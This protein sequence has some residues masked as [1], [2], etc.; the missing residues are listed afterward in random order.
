MESDKFSIPI[1]DTFLDVQEDRI[2]FSVHKVDKKE[3]N[4]FEEPEARFQ[5]VMNRLK[6]QLEFD[7]SCKKSKKS[8]RASNPSSPVLMPKKTTN[9][10]ASKIPLTGSGSKKMDELIAIYGPKTFIPMSSRS[11]TKAL[12]TS[13]IQIFKGLGTL[14]DSSLKKEDLKEKKYI[15]MNSSNALSYI[16]YAF[17][18]HQTLCLSPSDFLILIG[19]GLARHINLNSEKVRHQVVEHE[20][21]AKIMVNN[22]KITMKEECDWSELFGQFCEE[23]KKR[24]KKDIYSVVIDDFSTATPTTRILT[25]MTLMDCMKNYFRFEGARGCGFPKICL[26]GTVDDWKKFKEKVSKLKEMNKNDALEIDFWLK[27]LLPMV[28]KICEAGI[29]RK[30]DYTFWANLMCNADGYGGPTISGWINAFV[31][32]TYTREEGYLKNWILQGKMNDNYSFSNG[33]EKFEVPKGVSNVPFNF[34]ELDGKSYNMHCYS[35]SMGAKY[36]TKNDWIEAG[37]FWSV[38][39]DAK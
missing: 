19:F 2:T 36:D 22:P 23:I 8:K 7:S 27:H 30:V 33:L 6:K 35:G 15:K 38:Y 13:T 20:G 16:D 29:E 10:L 28:D 17:L 26:R 5:S 9:P 14:H 32:Y 4:D 11:S 24:V 37:Y 34:V 21:R 12:N 3:I 31:P 18:N 25:E 39:E 1:D